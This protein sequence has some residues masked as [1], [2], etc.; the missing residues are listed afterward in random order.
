YTWYPKI[1]LDNI[2]RYAHHCIVCSEAVKDS[3]RDIGFEKTSVL[4]NFIDTH[5]I[6]N[7][8]NRRISRQELGIN[9]DEFIWLISGHTNYWKG[10]QYLP[11][12]LKQLEGEKFRIIWVGRELDDAFYYYIKLILE[13]KY[14]NK[15]I[16]TGIQ[17]D[18]YYDYFA[19]ADG[20]LVLSLQESFSLVA[21]EASYFSLPI[22]SFEYGAAKEVLAG[23]T[24]QIIELF[25]VELFVQAMRKVMHEELINVKKELN[26]N[27]PFDKAQQVRRFNQL[28]QDL[29]D[30]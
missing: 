19:L 9:Q 7:L 28:L 4:H 1:Y 2:I 25:D 16:F 3:F 24:A 30:F 15:V 29:T 17:T 22:V 14:P 23:T 26:K 13:Q 8:R 11:A 12:I 27:I 6:D 10:I 20:F 18:K 21:M 5:K